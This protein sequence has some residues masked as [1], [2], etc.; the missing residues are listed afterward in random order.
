MVTGKKIIAIQIT[1]K[2]LSLKNHEMNLE[3]MS[4]E[5]CDYASSTSLQKLDRN[6]T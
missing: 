1:F 5:V 6:H 4:I 3:L 2:I